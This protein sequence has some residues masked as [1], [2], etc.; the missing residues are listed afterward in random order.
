MSQLRW[1]FI[2]LLICPYLLRAEDIDCTERTVIVAARNRNINSEPYALQAAD[3]RGKVN[4]QPVQILGATKP[5]ASTRVVL[6]LD[7]S[8]SMSSKWERAVDVAREI[9]QDSPSSTHFAAVIFADSVFKTIGFA[10]A[11]SDVST[12]LKTL[13][14]K[15]YGKTALYDG[16]WEAVRMLDAGQEGDSIVVIS[17]ASE[18]HSHIP[19]ERVRT[20]VLSRGI[21]VFF[22]QFADNYLQNDVDRMDAID[23][24][25]LS[26]T[27]GGLLSKMENPEQALKGAREIAFEIHN[28]LA[29]RFRA[30]QPLEKKSSLHLEAVESSERKRKDVEVLFPKEILSCASLRSSE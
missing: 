5:S 12:E 29:I 24:A 8:G 23:A 20:A 19:L 30:T 2:F 27:S 18:Y 21:R 9:I 7:A 15:P 6:V 14:V 28:Y 3:L 13:T 11:S 17:D 26:A 1:L 16:E 4:G 25:K 22:V 10:N